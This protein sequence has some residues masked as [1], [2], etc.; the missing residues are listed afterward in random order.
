[1][2]EKWLVAVS[3]GPD[4][5]ALLYLMMQAGYELSVAH[6]NYKQ[7]EI[8]DQEQQMV[9]TYCEQQGLPFY[10]ID[11]DQSLK[12]NFQANARNFRYAFFAQIIKEHQLEGVMVG[13]HLDDHIETYLIQQE[14]GMQTQHIGLSEKSIVKGILVYRPLLS[15]NKQKLID[16]CVEHDIPYSLDAS[17]QDPKYT[18]NRIRLMPKDI[19]VLEQEMKVAIENHAAYQATIETYFN[20]LSLPLINRNDYLKIPEEVRIDVLRYSLE[21]AGATIHHYKRQ[22]FVECDRQIEGG[23]AFDDL[24]K[25]NLY[26]DQETIAITKPQTY[27]YVFND[28][29][30]ITTSH[31]ILHNSGEKKQGI[32]FQESDFPITVRPVRKGDVIQMPFGRKKVHRYLIDAKVPRYLR[33]SWL[34]IENASNECIF[35][36]GLGCD[37]HH[38]ANNPDNFVLEL[39][40]L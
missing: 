24:G 18:R 2:K 13:H 38:Y 36:V 11:Y 9:K 27:H 30:P 15:E 28:A 33:E 31:F 25:V 35:V 19:E 34:V 10:T 17:N 4:S 40:L 21:Q 7:R 1:M 23:S 8:S 32:Q 16:L 22:F 39:N 5:M 6:V 29:T 26:C 37:V 20:E 14:R 12:G 3:G